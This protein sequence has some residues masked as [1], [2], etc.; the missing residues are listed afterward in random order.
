MALQDYLNKITCGDSYELIKKIP[1][2]SIDL[3][4]TDPP[5]DIETEGGKK[6]RISKSFLGCANELKAVD[7]GIDLKILDEFM[8]VM[9]KPN[10][11]IWCNKK[12]IPDYLNYFVVGGVFL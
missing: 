7:E 8:R 1:D 10:I 4:V 3:I 5:Y 11:Y 6:N 2:K 12:Q 9:K